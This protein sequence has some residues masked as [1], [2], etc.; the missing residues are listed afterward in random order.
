MFCSY[1]RPSSEL[2]SDD[3]LLS[4]GRPHFGLAW[5]T[6]ISAR[7]APMITPPRTAITEHVPGGGLLMIATEERCSAENPA[8][9]AVA[10]DIEAGLAPVNAQ[11]WPTGCL[12]RGSLCSAHRFV[13]TECALND[14][15]QQFGRGAQRSG[16]AK[17][18]AAP[19]PRDR[20][21]AEE[22]T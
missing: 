4:L 8:H 5:M 11:P 14:K 18:L 6:Y 20:P 3:K 9:M 21:S 12:T 7:F 17:Q 2:A 22:L 16:E 10:R 13:L 1:N 19:L 15:L